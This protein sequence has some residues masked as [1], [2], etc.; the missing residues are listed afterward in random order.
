MS[1]IKSSHGPAPPPYQCLGRA[2]E[3][4][5]PCLGRLVSSACRI[6][7]LDSLGYRTHASS[8]VLAD[9]IRRRCA[10][11]ALCASRSSCSS[12][13]ARVAN[14]TSIHQ[15]NNN[16]G[17]GLDVEQIV[18]SGYGGHV[19]VGDRAGG[20]CTHIV[21]LFAPALDALRRLA[22]DYGGWP[23]GGWVELAL[24]QSAIVAVD[25]R[26]APTRWRSLVLVGAQT[27]AAAGCFAA[28]ACSTWQASSVRHASSCWLTGHVSPDTWRGGGE[29]DF[30]RRETSERIWGQLVSGR[31]ES[32]SKSRE[33]CEEG[34]NQGSRT[35]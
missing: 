17:L 9:S 10:C 28:W 34:E 19:G 35:D 32:S 25:A 24:L 31:S 33:S 2:G 13:C 7:R 11:C 16:V 12:R 1:Q 5:R 27:A 21:Q 14:S 26:C 6:P 30:S 29:R 15:V 18:R 4:R 8:L 20:I 23:V 22:P 3:C